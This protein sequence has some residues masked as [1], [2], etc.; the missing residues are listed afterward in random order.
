MILQA[1]KKF[2]DTSH[3]A[4]LLTAG[5]KYADKLV[6]S[7]ERFY[8]ETDLSGCLF[9]M[10]GVNSAG[11]L[12]LETLSQEVM[13]TEIRLTWNVSPAAAVCIEHVQKNVHLFGN[14]IHTFRNIL[15]PEIQLWVLGVVFGEILRHNIADTHG[16]AVII[17]LVLGD[18][19]TGQCSYRNNENYSDQQQP[20]Q[21]GSPDAEP[22]VAFFS[23]LFCFFHGT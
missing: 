17:L 8:Q 22:V 2:I 10:R 11:N 15:L 20:D 3:V 13:E 18:R 19:I 12:A 5:E 14:F 9:V 21:E 4:H 7:V 6:F 16:I 23:T 1:N